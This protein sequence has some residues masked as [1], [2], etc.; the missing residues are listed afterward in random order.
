MSD[1][2]STLVPA[3]T[4]K[5]NIKAHPITGA[6]SQHPGGISVVDITSGTLISEPGY[7]VKVNASFLSGSD[8][9]KPDTSGDF[10]RLDV[11]SLLKDESGA[12]ITLNYT[13]HIQTTEAIF[14]VL[15]GAPDAKT[16]E[17]GNI[18]THLTFET[19]SE[20]L[21]LL[22]QKVYVG[23][24]RFIVEDGGLTVEYK[25]SQVQA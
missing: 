24:G 13:G 11:K 16:T 18:S 1:G 2:F 5:A 12:L 22:E 15:G 9:I 7:P 4:L 19:G 17:F 8:Y 6:T 10:F 21:R 20:D 23:N 14:K 25:I 3:F